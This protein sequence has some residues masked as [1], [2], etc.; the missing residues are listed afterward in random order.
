MVVG[1]A[2]L[3]MPATALA[4]EATSKS[5][6]GHQAKALA[7]EAGTT[8]AVAECVER[9]I[10]DN[11]IESCNKS[12]SPILPAKNEMI[13]GALSFLLLLGA[14]WKFGVPAA[15]GM[16]DARTDR[17]RND[18]D[19]AE[20]ARVE[21]ETVLADYQRQLADARTESSRII[22]EARQQAEQVRRDLT[23]RAEA[24]A[25]DLRQRNAD[26]VAGERDRVM[27]E[28]Q[29]QVG[30]LAIELAEKVVESSLD[31]EASQRLIES[32][33]NSVGTN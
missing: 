20:R 6:A 31:R 4:Q 14:L 9:A 22:E 26:Q 12:P 30:A 5:E 19:G 24:E 15:K 11:D 7:E 33:I 8:Q 2:V 29:T 18:L 32:Y 13:W 3:A 23:T 16:M 17:I 27:G 10:V 25:A 1:A 28:L 21:A